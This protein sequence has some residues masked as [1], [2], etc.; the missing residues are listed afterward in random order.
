[1]VLV[2]VARE[3][4]RQ[5]VRGFGRYYNLESK[6]FNK[7]YT[8]FPRSRLIGRGV[9]HGLATG[10]I[11]GTFIN[12]ADDTP[13]NG[14]QKPFKKQPATSQQNQARNRYT[15]GKRSRSNY[16]DRLD[17]SRRQSGTR[18]SKRSRYRMYN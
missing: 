13:G 9:R 5:A 2:P 17:K 15:S 18:Y 8:G 4:F 7:L 3:I 12:T 1:M 14:V 11:A 16:C 10:S 6:A